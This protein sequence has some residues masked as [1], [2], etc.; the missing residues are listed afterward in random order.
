MILELLLVVMLLEAKSNPSHEYLQL[1][2]DDP[3]F[4]CEELLELVLT[5]H[6]RL[7][8]KTLWIHRF[9]LM[10]MS[11]GCAKTFL[12]AIYAILRA[13]LFSGEKIVL[14]APSFRQ[15]KLIFTEIE[16]WVNNSPYAQE[17]LL[18][19][20]TH[21]ADNY[22]MNFRNGSWIMA[23][24]LGPDGAKIR[25]IRATV[26]IIDEAAQVPEDVINSVIIPFMAVKRNPAA[27]Y[28]GTEDPDEKENTLIYSSS[29]YYKFNY[30]Y[31][32]Y[33]EWVGMVREGHPDYGLVVLDSRHVPE[34]FMDEAA[35][36][37]AKATTPEHIFRMEWLNEWVSDTTGFY[38]A[39]LIEECWENG[40]EIRPLKEGR[41]DKNYVL[42]VDPARSGAGDYYALSIIELNGDKR[43]LVY[44][45]SFR[46]LT[47]PEMAN[48]VDRAHILFPTIE[49]MGFDN[50]GGRAVADILA[51]PRITL[52]P[53]T[54][55][56]VKREPLLVIGEEEKNT[57]GHITK[58]GKRI[59]NL[60]VFSS[61]SINDMNFNMKA[62]MEQGMLRFPR[63]DKLPEDDELIDIYND[64]KRC[65]D[66]C[67][68][69]ETEPTKLGYLRFDV[70]EKQKKDN[71]SALLIANHMAELLQGQET[72]EIELP[73]GFWLPMS[74]G[75]FGL[76]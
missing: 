12:D 73:A 74:A 64:I 23:I 2:R 51:Q 20:V 17:A 59:I 1:L 70:P 44:S 50:A 67:V 31:R 49:L 57:P 55:K 65:A 35:F 5:P 53:K 36:N 40:R 58:V 4:A 14:V 24:P 66:Q 75:E 43:D 22:L 37:H 34:G 62:R 3:C 27:K 32:M 41:K 54:G 76:I 45:E 63:V 9:N 19:K 28:T 15:T 52:H 16:K 33:L 7:A 47:F 56:P 25:G 60:V 13:L 38:P 6:E 68:L 30:L 61:P 10:I 46:G 11:R 18:G 72:E 21:N 39:S 29:A 8:L 69:I 48:R 26:I 42:G 71:Y